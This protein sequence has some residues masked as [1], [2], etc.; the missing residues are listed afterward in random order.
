MGNTRKVTIEW[1]ERIIALR[2]RLQ[3]SQTELGKRVN[4]SAMAV[5]RW[6]RGVQE[7]TAG[8]H[9][10]LGNLTGDPECWYFWGRA[11]LQSADLMRVL[12]DVRSRMRKDHLHVVQDGE[13]SPARG[14]HTANLV[15]VP[16]LPVMVAAHGGEGDS[17][18]LVGQAAP[19]TM[20]AAPSAWCPNP[21]YIS[22]LRVRGRSMMP[23]IHDGYIVAVDTLQTDRAKL[24]GQIV[25]AAH[26]QHG[27]IISRFQRIDRVELLVPENREYEPTTFSAG[28]WRL[29]GKALWWIGRAG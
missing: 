29:V 7:P 24:C 1:A 22:C 5:S 20:L 10:Q 2:K 13:R 26:K 16:V 28:G 17:P 18:D 12:P 25:V 14:R 3:L 27:L 19:E 6:E 9:I 4:A 8:I 15:A 11:G 23:L 21:A